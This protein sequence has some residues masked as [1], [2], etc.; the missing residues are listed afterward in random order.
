M[1]LLFATT[2]KRKLEDLHNIVSANK[3]DINILGLND[4]GWKDADI[5]ENGTSLEENSLIKARTVYAYCQ[6]K[7][8]SYT[9][10]TDDAG[11]F[12]ETLEGEP[13]IYTARYAD[14]EIKNNPTLPKYQCLYKL[15][16]KMAEQKN[17]KAY[18]KCVTT[19][20]FP[21][22]AYFQE[23]GI[24]EGK[25]AE[26]IKTPIKKPYFYSIF[27]VD[28]KSFNELGLEELKKTYRYQAIENSLKKISN[29]K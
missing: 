13:G 24:T 2:N 27:M 19:C 7:G 20:M 22:K 16:E 23:I 10:L 8:L 3:L 26:E 29:S 1:D 25:I 11:L 12:V 18:Y 4:I 6:S 28:E 17:R 21:D 5:E 15:L 9:I 14:E